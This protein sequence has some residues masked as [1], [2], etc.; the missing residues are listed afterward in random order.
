M[1][2]PMPIDPQSIHKK[3]EELTKEIDNLETSE[4]ETKIHDFLQEKLIPFV[5]VLENQL[6]R[7]LFLFSAH[8]DRITEIEQAQDSMLLPEDSE[9]VIEY[10]DKTLDIFKA[11]KKEAKSVPGIDKLIKEGEELI[12]F[13]ESITVDEDDGDGEEEDGS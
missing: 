13:I 11:L 4:G 7:I 9:K 6:A 12:T 8:E 1:Q 2:A 5:G 3:F 10:I